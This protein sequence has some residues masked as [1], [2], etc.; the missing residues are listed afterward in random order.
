MR[1]LFLAAA[2]SAVFI[3]SA[4]AGS[5]SIN[6]T[7]GPLTG[8]A[9]YTVSDADATKLIAYVQAAY[10]DRANPAFDPACV[11]NPNAVPPVLS[12]PAAR[13]TNN[14]AQSLKTWADGIVAGTIANVKSAQQATATKT[15]ADAI[16]PIDIK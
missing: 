8:T 5:L 13:L 16:A 15:A 6:L 4:F 12:C 7:S 14:A 9:T 3:G 2:L 10:P 1:K 11:V